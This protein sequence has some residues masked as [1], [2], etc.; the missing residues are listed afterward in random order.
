M[1]RKDVRLG[2][3]VTLRLTRVQ[4]IFQQINLL[5]SRI[6]YQPSIIDYR[7]ETKVFIKGFLY[8]GWRQPS[9]STIRGCLFFEKWPRSNNITLNLIVKCFEEASGL[10]VNVAKSRTFGIGVE[11]GEV[12]IIAYSLGLSLAGTA[13]NAIPTLKDPKFWTGEEK[14]TQKI[15]RLARSLLIIGLPNDIY[16]LIDSNDTAKD[17]RDALERQ[18][19]GLKKVEVQTESEGSDD[20]DT[21]DLKNIIALL[22][23]A[24]NRKK[25]YAKP[26]NNNLRTSS[27]SFL[28]NKKPDVDLPAP[29]V[30][31]LI[32]EV[33][34]PDPAASTSSPSSTTI[35]QD[36]TSPSNSQTTPETQTSII[37]N[38]V[39]EDNHD[40]DVA[41]MN[42]DPFV[43]NEESPKTPTFHDDPL[44]EFLYEDSNS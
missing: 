4:S 25:Y 8:R 28:A 38:D 15:D 1:A 33:V 13:P 34:A 22:A 41:H 7:L 21:S 36:A 20:E 27:T 10:K 23:K 18:M 6:N 35:E 24:F 26:T 31:A 44:H 12:E 43:G 29:E 42:N 32:G 16:S 40:L 5:N 2:H 14:K 19:C 30:I 17:L 3:A 37:S 9:S 39:E 11:T